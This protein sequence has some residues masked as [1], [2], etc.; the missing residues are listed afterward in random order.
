MKSEL[1]LISEPLAVN[2]LHAGQVPVD[3]GGTGQ[4][5]DQ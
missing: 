4:D 3:T 1:A 5:P 2:E